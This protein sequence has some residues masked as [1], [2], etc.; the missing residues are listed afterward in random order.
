MILVGHLLLIGH[1]GEAKRVRTLAA[2]FLVALAIAAV[3]LGAAPAGVLAEPAYEKIAGTD[4]YQTA[5]Q[6][7]Q[8]GYS[9]GVEAVVIATGENYPDALSAA[10]L[11]A[12]YG[13]PV[14]LTRSAVLDEATRAEIARLRPGKI[15]V[16]GLQASVVAEIR[17]A[18]PEVGATGG[19]VPLIGRNRYDTARLVAEE[20]GSR[21]G[22][23]TGAVIVPGDSFADALAVAPL[24]AFR[25]WPIL[26]TPRGGPVPAET[27]E[28]LVSLGVTNGLV[29]GTYAEVGVPGFT[30]KRVA[31]RDRYD[32]SAR[33]AELAVAEGLS[34]SY[35]GVATGDNF[36]DALAAGPYLAQRGG[37]LLL[38]QSEEAD[39]S[40]VLLLRG[41]VHRQRDVYRPGPGY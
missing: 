35:L 4:R 27:Q 24:A 7:S 2:V 40:G 3:I 25:G 30:Y 32:T 31:G 37:V 28:A 10:P 9:P 18:F 29:V 36:P 11:A 8:R 16:V 33:L 20:V 17:G 41:G 23:V 19:I 14:L 21:L 12:A 13:G 15:Y 22:E 39:A 6:I 26:L 38:V 1:Q 34:Y 5:I